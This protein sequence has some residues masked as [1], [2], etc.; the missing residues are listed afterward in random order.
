MRTIALLLFLALSSHVC[1]SQNRYWI[2]SSGGNW[3]NSANWSTTS[4]GTGGASVPGTSDVAIFNATRNGNC[5]LDI[6]PTVGGITMNGYSGSVNLNGNNLRTTGNNTFAS[7]SLT[8]SGSTASLVLNT[9]GSATFSGTS[10]GVPV[11]GTTGDLTFNGSTFGSTVTIEKTSANGNT[12]SGGNTF[13][14]AVTL[15]NSGDGDLN[16]GNTNGDIFN[17]PV[18][19]NNTGTARINLAYNSPGNVFAAGLTINHGGNT[20]GTNT[21]VARNPNGRVTINGPLTLNCTNLSNNSGIIIANDGQAIINGNVVVSCTSGRGI[22][23]GGDNGA[24][25]GTVALGSGVTITSSA[26]SFTTGVLSFIRT[27]QSSATTQNLTLGGTTNLTIGPSTTFTG[28]V[29]FSSPQVLLNGGT[30]GGTAT[31]EKTG[32]TDNYSVGGNVFNGAATLINSGSGEFIFGNGSADTFTG[33]ATFNDIGSSRIRIAHNHPGQ[34]TSFTTDATFNA[35]KSSGTDSWAFLIGEVNDSNLSF[36]GNLTFNIAGSLESDCRFLNGAGSTGTVTGTLTLNV[37]NTHP[38]TVMSWGVNGSAQHNGDIVLNNTGGASGITLSAGASLMSTLSSGRLISIGSGGF[39]SG[40]LTITRFTQAGSTTQNL[41]TFSGTAKLTLN[42]GSTFNGPVNFKAPNIMLNGVICNN[43]AT[44]EK[45]GNT[46]DYAAGGNTFNGTTTIINSGSAYLLTGA[47]NAD[48]FNGPTTT[49]TNTGSHRIYLAHSHSGQVTVFTGD[50]IFNNQRTTATDNNAF[51]VSEYP[52][53]NVSFRRSV[54]INL[55][56]SAPSAFRLGGGSNTVATFDGILRISGTNTNSG[57]NVYVG[58]SGQCV[59]NNDIVVSQTGSVAGIYF[60][61]NTGSSSTL[62]PGH[63][64]MLD[65]AGFVSGILSLAR[66]TQTGPSAQTLN[67]FSGTARL[68][69]GPSSSFG[70]DVNFKAP[71]INFSG[72]VFGGIA[73]LEKSGA[74]DNNSNG[75][76][77]FNSSATLTNSGSGYMLLGNGAPDTFNGTTTFNNTG[78]FR[79]YVAYSH[80]NQA[81]KFASDV[82]FYANK[83]SGP[84]PWSYLIGESTNT[85]IEFGGNVSFICDGTLESDFR[86]L[87]GLTST[88]SFAGT[89]TANIRNTSTATTLVLGANGSASYSNNIVV[90]SAG[91]SILF[92]LNASA[93]STLADGKTISIGPDGF[94]R[95]TLGL[96]RFTQIGNTAQALSLSNGARLIIGPTS[97]F[98]GNVNFAAPQVLLNGATYN[99]TATLEKNGGTDNYSVGGNVFNGFTTV[100]NSGS[101]EF[102]FGNNNADA[103]N[104]ETVFNN[105]GSSRIRIAYNHAGQTTNFVTDVTLNS[106]KSS[107]TDQWS[108]LLSDGNTSSVFFGGNL[109]INDAGSLRND[110]RFL[111]GIGTTATFNGVVTI[112]NTNTSAN[113]TISMGT[114][115]IST[116][117]N[118]IIVSNSGGA[119]GIY[120]NTTASSSST[121]ADG[122]SIR[123]GAGGYTGGTLSLP[124]FMQSGSSTA[125]TLVATSAGSA[126]FFIGPGSTFNSNVNFSA[127]QLYLNGAIYNGNFN[128]LEKSGGG[129]NNSN[130]GNTFNNTT[131]ITNSGT[132][133]LVL[134]NGTADVFTGPASINNTGG[135]RIYIANSH[136]GQTTTFTDV[137]LNS[138]KNSSADPWSFLLSENA[139][140]TNISTSGNFTINCSGTF[141]S[142][143]RLLQGGSGCSATFGG[144][145]TIN[146]SNTN[147]GTTVSMGTNGTTTYN[148][149]IVVSNSGGASGVFFNVNPSASSTLAGRS[150]SIGASGFTA[151]NLQ[152][153]RFTQTGSSSAQT[154]NTLSGASVLTVG[155]SSSFD[156]AVTF[157]APQVFLSGAVYNNTAYI[158]KNGGNNNDSPGGNSFN[159]TTT[160]VNSSGA[161]MRMANT[162]GDAYNGAVTFVKSSTGALDPAYNLTSTFA[163]NIIVNSNTALTFGGGTGVV[164]FTGSTD[165]TL[166]KAVST[167]SPVYQRMRTNKAAGSSVILTHDLSVLTTATFSSGIVKTTSTSYLN[168]ADNATAT[169][170]NDL[171]YVEGPVRKTGNDT[172]VFPVGGGNFY[173]SIALASVPGSTSDV[174]TAQYFKAAQ[175][176]GD[177]TKWDP[178]F[179]TVSGCEYWILD[180][181]TGSSNVNVALSWNEAACGTGYVTQPSSLRVTRWNG[182]SWVNHGNG[183]TTGTSTAGTVVTSAA[184]TSFSPFT[185]ASTTGNNPLPV[186]LERFWAVNNDGSVT[187]RWTTVTENN[188]ATFSLQRS[189]NGFDF[190]TIYTVA[191]AGTNSSR[192]Q[193]SH[194]DD[195]PLPGQSYYRLVQTDYDGNSESWLVSV[196]REGEDSPFIIW[197]N[198]AGN[199]TVYFNQKAS[200]VIMN[201]LG[202]VIATQDGVLSIDASSLAPGVYTILNQKGQAA[203]LVRK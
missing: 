37:T 133:Y 108:F 153:T 83:S 130:G 124:R 91:G 200:I 176:Y 76:N 62:A 203:R 51:S 67:T 138:F 163:N 1:L 82:T 60:N 61:Y 78:S 186:G 7:G 18:V 20:N 39:N 168:F 6:A 103:F 63:T 97:T 147:N 140:N 4:G 127:P 174:F 131:T 28:N 125:Q 167:P 183:G 109:T 149:D 21:I 10:I 142:N 113:T 139:N 117:N 150:I 141:Q 137:T 122:H 35:N 95:G 136:P 191:G 31:F 132:G 64:I 126:S 81:T 144:L 154:L 47:T 98:N 190:E 44:I 77:T 69:I 152:L 101:A 73:T 110:I 11:T 66:F 114:T 40:S 74:T 29:S 46:N 45:T 121:L 123:I 181:T 93:S 129:N 134:G 65:G 17:G 92:N 26:G 177:R 25:V 80:P 86:I 38:S 53:S 164:E 99:G 88:A 202:Q 179:Y 50:V 193:Y 90:S 146:V 135:S 128:T 72:T 68:I 43:T 161:R 24:T 87:Q 194:T 166:S 172:F 57:S 85:N 30:Y 188:N 8:N 171:S 2:S 42:P 36:G 106:N 48:L 111:N 13:S 27:T 170:A 9:T 175:S 115:G 165:Q 22:Y 198:P 151:G 79:I 100:T 58:L 158:E 104:A 105:T 192:L 56:G 119:S 112:N 201:N 196:S 70:G 33:T 187:L 84:D 160:L 189:A 169:G 155:P 107:G 199:E 184:V 182:S 159:G 71:Q 156:G 49:F 143:Y 162:T 41:D 120:F 12:G 14:G 157:V 180:R 5:T 197:P 145:V 148:G 19:V 116:Y 15:T 32:A 102:F 75:G 195:G 55:D 3:N 178:S 54:T 96:P 94:G 173:R 23:F 34:T 89:V 16:L 52:D 185:L 59:F 118:D